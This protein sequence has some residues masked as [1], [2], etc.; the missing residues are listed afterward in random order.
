MVC[1]KED[2]EEYK[3]KSEILPPKFKMMAKMK[4]SPD[5]GLG[6]YLQGR[7][8]PVKVVRKHSWTGLGFKPELKCW[9]RSKRG[10]VSRDSRSLKKPQ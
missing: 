7:R 10:S 5:K 8:E 4:F 2:V 6:K 3:K 9:V 1:T